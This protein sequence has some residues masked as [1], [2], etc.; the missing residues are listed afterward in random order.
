MCN[1][2]LSCYVLFWC[3]F[4]IVQMYYGVFAAEKLI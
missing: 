4:G 3:Y 1:S 2:S